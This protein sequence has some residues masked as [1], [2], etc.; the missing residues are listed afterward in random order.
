MKKLASEPT[1]LLKGG[2]IKRIRR[3][4]NGI[5]TVSVGATGAYGI[6]RIAGY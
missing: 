4:Y 1:L 5:N 3:Y 6:K 2:I